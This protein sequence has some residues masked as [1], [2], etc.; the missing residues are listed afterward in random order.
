MSSNPVFMVHVTTAMLSIAMF[1]VR[2]FGMLAQARWMQWRGVR[3]VPHIND[4][5]LLLSAVWLAL[6]THQ[7]PLQQPWLSAKVVALLVYIGLGMVA[8][9]FGRSRGVRLAAW[10][11]A[12]A[13]FGYIVAVATTRT[14]WPWTL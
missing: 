1:V 4:T 14:P 8:L 7:Y 13:V 10:L 6:M 3:I 5:I 11:G 2:G 9:R 12:I